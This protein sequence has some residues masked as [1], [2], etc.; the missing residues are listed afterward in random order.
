MVVGLLS[1]KDKDLRAVGLDQVRTEAKGA[2]A[3]KQFAAQ[4][5]K[6]MPAAQA[7]LLSALADRGDAAA[8]PA[9]LEL[10]TASK[11]ESVRVA[12]IAAIGA[13]GGADDLPVLLKSLAGGSTVEKAAARASLEKL[14]GE[15]VPGAIAA[16]L[17]KSPPPLRVA[18][19]EILTSRR[20]LETVPSILP[21]AVDDDPAVRVAAMTA[22]G[23]M[24][25]AEHIP[26]MLSGVLKA[27]KGSER[28]AAETAVAFVCNRVIDPDTKFGRAGPV[29]AAILKLQAV[30]S[31]N[32]ATA[33]IPAL[34]RIGGPQALAEVKSYLANLQS[35]NK[36]AKSRADAG[37]EAMCKWTDAT[38]ADELLALA[39]KA[40]NDAH[41]AMT[42]QA[43]V[44]VGSMRDKRPDLAR[45]DRMKQ[46]MSIAKSPEE[47]TLVIKGCR[48]AYV[49]ESLRYVLPYLDQPQFAQIACETVV[50][51]AHHRELREPN[52]TEFDPA[53]DKVMKTSKDAVVVDRADRYKKGQTWA[54]P[55]PAEKP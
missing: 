27:M 9:V 19:I 32:E 37:L 36:W 49:V 39:E 14:R 13:L 30:D 52:K 54:R 38:V 3:T 29:I 23:Q 45:L 21:S 8:R 6:L 28:D 4:L 47:K 10:L 25:K 18:L 53:L 17:K 48:A 24:A 2:A 34:G 51:L 12:A 41:R 50:E 15:A 11:D 1:D 16:E 55:K 5:P 20:A 7:A 31:D 40:D 46:A 44:R 42:F 33:L 22:L 43:L 35:R 26:D